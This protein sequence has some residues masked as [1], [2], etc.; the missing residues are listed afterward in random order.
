MVEEGSRE[1]EEEEEDKT[2]S[3]CARDSCLCVSKLVSLGLSR[4]LYGS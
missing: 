1:W 4:K 2:E 3:L